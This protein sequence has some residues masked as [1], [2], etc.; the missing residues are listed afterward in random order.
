MIVYA[1]LWP[2]NM[3]LWLPYSA[4]TDRIWVP[5]VAETTTDAVRITYYYDGVWVWEP[6]VL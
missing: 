3:R 1:F 4:P 6:A 2:F 5:P